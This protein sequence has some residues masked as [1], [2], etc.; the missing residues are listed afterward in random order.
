MTTTPLRLLLV[1]DESLIAMLA[2]DLIEMVGHE[3]V[4]TAATLEEARNACV[5]ANFDAALLDACPA[6][7]ACSMRIAW[8]LT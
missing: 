4:T 8:C 3:V 5:V 1:E 2:E 7:G 6:G